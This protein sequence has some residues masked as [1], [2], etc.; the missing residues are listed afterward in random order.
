MKEYD[1]TQNKMHLMEHLRELRKRLVISFALVT[2]GAIGCYCYAG[3]IFSILCAPF[4]QAF[5]NSPLIGTSPAEAWVLKLKVS[6]VAGAFLMSPALFYQLWLFISPGLYTRERRLVLPFVVLSTALFLG[7]AIFCYISVI[8][9]S[10]AFF[11]DE[12]VSIGVTPTIRIG[13]QVSMTL[14]TVVGFGAVFEL[15]LITYFLTRLGIL[16]HTTLIR[17]FRH[18]LV[19]IF[20]L[21]AVITPPD[22]FSQF[23]LAVPLTLLY[24]LSI[25]IAYLVT[26]RRSAPGHNLARTSPEDATPAQV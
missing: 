24:T 2:I 10:F 22:V 15:P 9:L 26:R 19:G 8:P 23:L 16:D 1:P 14:T 21:A 7:G 17:F 5:P 18:A 12:F 6:V 11:R 3:E 20:F 4:F 25:G 13:D